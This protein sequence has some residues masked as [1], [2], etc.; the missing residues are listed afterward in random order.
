MATEFSEIFSGRQQRQDIKVFQRF[1]TI[2]VP[3]FKMCWWFG[4]TQTFDHTLKIGTELVSKR[5]NTLISLCGCLLE[6]I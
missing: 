3:I 5:R 6:K 1:G 4:R 2:S